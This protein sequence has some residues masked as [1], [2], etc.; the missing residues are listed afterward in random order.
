MYLR[1][2]YINQNSNFDKIAHS[3][4]TKANN[5]SQKSWKNSKITK[6]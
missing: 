5:F 1:L 6:Y 3:S 4:Q 2:K